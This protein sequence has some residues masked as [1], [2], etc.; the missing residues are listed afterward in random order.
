VSSILVAASLKPVHT[1]T[2]FTFLVA[3]TRMKEKYEEIEL[4]IIP[5]P[6]ELRNVHY[7]QDMK[8][9]GV[10]KD[11]KDVKQHE[12]LCKNQAFIFLF[13]ETVINEKIGKLI[14]L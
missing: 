14:I 4:K 11:W 12:A 3:A 6:E 5:F 10:K 2:F 13:E 8:M 7:K 9:K 1:S